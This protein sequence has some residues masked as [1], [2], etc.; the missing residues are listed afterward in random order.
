MELRHTLHAQLSC[1]CI[2]IVCR[3]I[4]CTNINVCNASINSSLHPLDLI[5]KMAQSVEAHSHL[6]MSNTTHFW[7]SL[8]WSCT[9]SFWVWHHPAPPHYLDRC[10][11]LEWSNP[12]SPLDPLL[13]VASLVTSG[14]LRVPLPFHAPSRTLWVTT[15]ERHTNKYKKRKKKR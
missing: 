14:N 3:H 9:H 2:V 6:P 12:G 7:P 5:L 8:N 15:R 1:S 4:W 11:Q 10:P 13:A